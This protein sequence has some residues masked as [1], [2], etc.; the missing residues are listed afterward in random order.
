MYSGSNAYMGGNSA[1]PGQQPPF[2]PQS[3]FQQQPQPT[4]YAGVQAP[5]QNQY[6]GF[7]GQPQQAFGQQ[8][9]GYGQPQ[10]QQQQ[11]PQQAPAQQPQYTG[12]QQPLSQQ[13]T[14]FQQ[15]QQQQQSQAPPMPAMPQQYQQFQ[16]TPQAAPPQQ[17]F[18]QPPQQTAPPAKAQLPQV[19]GMTSA[20]MADSFR[21]TS[22]QPV[23]PPKNNN[24]GSKIPNIRLSFITAQDQAKFEQLF[25]S[26]VGSAQ[27]LSGDQARDI[28]LRSK[29]S[30]D[31][32]G[33]IW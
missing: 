11:A 28:L 15:F 20:Q 25:K 32:L 13:Q 29:L 6:T 3:S 17:S 10:Q 31:D 16:A 21:G 14:G 12:F 33:N 4:G 1:R 18:Q 5:L 27:A 26:A 23:P 30:G 2:N 24:A 19:T 9:T 8:Q 22:S 7:P